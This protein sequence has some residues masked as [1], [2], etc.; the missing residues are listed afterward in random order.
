MC[1]WS[2]IP[3]NCIFSTGAHFQPSHGCQMKVWLVRYVNTHVKTNQAWSQKIN[4]SQTSSEIPQSVWMAALRT[5]DKVYIN[6]F[7]AWNSH[8]YFMCPVFFFLFI[9]FYIIYIN[10]HDIKHE[11]RVKSLAR[12]ATT[13]LLDINNILGIP[14]ASVSVYMGWWVSFSAMKFRWQGQNIM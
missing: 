11:W 12:W 8:T 6:I 3:Y 14:V 13:E 7:N 4:A 9:Y 10:L 1:V 5:G 2:K